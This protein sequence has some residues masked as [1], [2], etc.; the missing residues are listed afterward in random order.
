MKNTLLKNKKLGI[1]GGLLFSAL[2]FVTLIICTACPQYVAL[3]GGVDILPPS[4]E[5]TYPDAGETPI[6]GSFVLKGTAKDD[7]GVKA[8]SI[9]FEDIETKAKTRSFSAEL[10]SPGSYNV[11]WSANINNESTGTV[12]NH[13]LVKVYPIPDGE[14]TAI[15]TVTDSNDK[16]SKFT[17][18]YK[19]DNTPPVFII[20]RPSTI[21]VGGEAIA[22]ADPYGSVFTVVG[23]AEDKNKIEDLTLT[24]DGID[25]SVSKKFVGK[26]INE[27]MAAATA[28]SS[29]F[30]DPLYKYNDDHSD[31]K[32]KAHVFLTDNARFFKG[33]G[34]PGTGN[35][36]E[37]YYLRDKDIREILDS[38]Y[39]ADIINDYFAGK[40]G[41][42][43]SSNKADKLLASLYDEADTG[44]QKV[45]HILEST[46]I[47]TDGSSVLP[48]RSSV[49]T[50]DPNKSPG[51]KITGA[52]NLPKILP[53][54]TADA[55]LPKPS[56]QFFNG[57]APPT[58]LID[59]IP[60]KTPDALVDSYDYSAY[61]D[62]G[63]E[64][65]M[66]K[67]NEVS[68]IN[69]GGSKKLDVIPAAAPAYSFKLADLTSQHEAD[70]AVT[71][72]GGNQLTVKWK[73][74]GTFAQGHYV[75]Q[76]KGKDTKGN[77]FTAYND[78]N[79]PGGVFFIDF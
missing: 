9:V 53:G 2:L 31:P 26:N 70:G 57:D 59:L 39:T 28:D 36:S 8:V 68:Y 4:G 42:A 49:F 66:Y 77:D 64:I 44:A 29:G 78:A 61:R 52:T 75:I 5:I 46:R 25:I 45:K 32:I 11:T 38:G 72:T 12:P 35:T 63:I 62:S 30:T 3:G 79:A 20:S 18:N 58:L 22:A 40:K 48:Q 55:D 50:L 60:N 43:G 7:E 67:C 13:E 14:Y 74:P 23:Q 71:L 16:T 47:M 17:K 6:R 37:W 56:L 76:V 69:E 24:V 73:L 51:F 33:D 1:K 15:V 10:S 21:A 34:V 19:I 54:T 27:E 41:N 65:E